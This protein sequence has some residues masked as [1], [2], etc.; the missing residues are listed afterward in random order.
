MSNDQ[1]LHL[2]G[3][4]FE[5]MPEPHNNPAHDNAPPTPEPQRAHE[6]AMTHRQILEHNRQYH[7]GHE[8]H[9]RR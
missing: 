9:D 8:T 2:P 7:P 6:V 1:P 5:D 3:E 4:A